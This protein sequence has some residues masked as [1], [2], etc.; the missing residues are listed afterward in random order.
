VSNRTG[1]KERADRLLVD[2][3]LVESR[4]K[5]Q[6]VIMAGVVRCDGRRVD[7]AG[8]KLATDATLEVVGNP[9]PYVG[10]G[11]LKMEAALQDF[12]IDPAGMSALD[13]GASTGG[14]VDC[15]L[16][17]GAT[18][19]CA[20]DV[21]R[22]QL[23]WKLRQDP[24]VRLMEGVNA[25]YLT[26]ED[27]DETFDIATVDVSFIS[28][29]L[30]LPAIRTSAPPESYVL[31]VKPQFEVG[32]DQ[33]ERGGLVTDSAKHRRVLREIMQC[34]LDQELPPAG[35]RPSPIRGAKGNLEFLLYLKPGLP[36]PPQ[37]IMDTWIE[38]AIT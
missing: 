1:G 38:E 37:N 2:R 9:L 22:G 24:R 11:G 36:A 3:G 33:V 18:S 4:E 5:A 27:F 7:K 6:A 26:A 29:R 8:E 15:L 23:H 32:R 30:I 35:L 34:A 31:L 17:H 19:V 20:V 14:F 16:Q 28:L 10:R 13:V 21:G 25:R 12:R